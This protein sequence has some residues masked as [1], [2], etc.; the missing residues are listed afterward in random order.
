VV[1][2]NL[3][4]DQLMNHE[5]ATQIGAPE[6]YALGD[7]AADERDA[8]EEHFASCARCMDEVMTATVFAANTRAVFRER[9]AAAA[10]RARPR[11]RFWAFRWQFAI[12]TL[13]AAALAVVAVYQNNVTIPSLRAP[14]AAL[15]AMILDGTTRASLPQVRAG[16]PL[17][18]QMALVPGAQGGRAW[19]ELSGDSG[20]VWS[21]GW[22]KLISTDE[23][24][25]SFPVRPGVGRYIIVVRSD[26]P[27]GAPELAR[28]RFEITA[29]EP[30]TR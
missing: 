3:Y 26:A 20:H 18:F 6:R 16:A 7:L 11:E 21:A 28:N 29:E 25:V 9:A 17:S 13:A 22:V 5:T 14:Q 30:A 8:F 2:H 24:D 23:L 12:P 27:V 1:F 15:P 10:E 4:G 19:V